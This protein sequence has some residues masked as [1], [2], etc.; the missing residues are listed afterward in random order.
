MRGRIIII[1]LTLAAGAMLSSCGVTRRFPEGSYML[2]RNV[3]KADRHTP[4]RERITATELDRYVLPSTNHHFLGTNLYPWLWAQ[5]DPEKQTGWHNFLRGAGEQPIVW[6]PAITARSVDN[7][8][9]YIA[10][11]GFFSGTIDAR[12][13]TLRRKKVSVTY[14]VTQGPPSHIGRI[15]RTFRDTTLRDVVMADS[16]HT[17][18]HTGD[19]FDTGVMDD[20]RSRITSLLRD[21]GYYNFNVGH[22]TYIADSTGSAT[23][24]RTIDIDMT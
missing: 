17:L 6:N 14:R 22:I 2:K 9:T 7:L 19:I 11:R 5:A 3:I 4:R 24:N 20:E 1:A 18:L 10:L 23:R 21:R 16:I 15:T 8:Q 13:D 12:V